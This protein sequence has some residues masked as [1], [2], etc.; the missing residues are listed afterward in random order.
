MKARSIRLAVVVR[1]CLRGSGSSL[2]MQACSAMFRSRVTSGYQVA[3]NS[4]ESSV[5]LV[6]EVRVSPPKLVS[7]ALRAATA[8]QREFYI[9]EALPATVHCQLLIAIT[10]SGR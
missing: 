1:A 3:T 2:G 4:G 10:L 7:Q 9:L 5:Q 8:P 6:L